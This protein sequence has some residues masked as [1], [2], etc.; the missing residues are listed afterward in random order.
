M[1]LG[2]LKYVF[3]ILSVSSATPTDYYKARV[4]NDLDRLVEVALPSPQQALLVKQTRHLM[5]RLAE[6]QRT[7]ALAALLRFT[8]QSYNTLLN[9]QLTMMNNIIGFVLDQAQNPP[10]SMIIQLAFRLKVDLDIDMMA[11]PG[12]LDEIEKQ[13]ALSRIF[14]GLALYCPKPPAMHSWLPDDGDVEEL[15]RVADVIERMGATIARVSEEHQVSVLHTFPGNA[16]CKGPRSGSKKERMVF[17]AKQEAVIENPAAAHIA[18]RGAHLMNKTAYFFKAYPEL[19]FDH[20]FSLSL[21]FSPRQS[22][23]AIAEALRQS[24]LAIL[25]NP[26]EEEQ[27]LIAQVMTLFA[28]QPAIPL[29]EAAPVTEIRTFEQLAL[30]E[31][32]DR[33]LHQPV[34]TAQGDRFVEL[35]KDI[36]HTIADTF[37][38]PTELARLRRVFTNKV[39]FPAGCKPNLYNYLIDFTETLALQFGYRILVSN[40]ETVRAVFPTLTED[41]I[42]HLRMIIASMMAMNSYG[43]T[44]NL[45]QGAM[46]KK[47]LAP[48][49]MAA[50]GMAKAYRQFHQEGDAQYIAFLPLS[51]LTELQSAD[52]ANEW[53]ASN[54][55][56]TGFRR[57]ALSGQIAEMRS[58]INAWST[59]I[60][61]SLIAVENF[62]TTRSFISVVGRER[63]PNWVKMGLALPS[64]IFLSERH[65]ADQADQA[66]RVAKR[67]IVPVWIEMVKTLFHHPVE[68]INPSDNED[69][70]KLLFQFSTNLK[71]YDHEQFQETTQDYER[72]LAQIATVLRRIRG[73]PEPTTTRNPEA[74]E[75]D[76]INI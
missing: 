29:K 22:S 11:I 1:R 12:F 58:Q 47:K 69:L 43:K 40:A 31:Q 26:L 10:I 33:A 57:S 75:T 21:A 18:V 65:Q 60:S 28:T 71:T 61:D 44:A 16:I 49:R 3:I 37:S 42:T 34:R 15:T 68:T 8:E 48:L 56:F 6:S 63:L 39:V 25:N 13:E 52:K 17:L 54:S 41:S 19:Q 35:V 38:A 27:F 24:V 7:E 51:I 67:R 62:M 59:P 74:A 23:E 5:H 30:F 2:S 50:E 46:T 76:P 64:S 9:R 72:I 4:L 53:L 73:E 55:G 70:R 45:V 32:L 36:V 20:I 66:L 14:T